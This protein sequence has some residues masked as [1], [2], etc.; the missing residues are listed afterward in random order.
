MWFTP[1]F[2]AFDRMPFGPK[3]MFR[4]FDMMYCISTM[5][6]RPRGAAVPLGDTLLVPVTEGEGHTAVTPE[7]HVETRPAER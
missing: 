2:I 5:E 6:R 1:L 3:M 4:A 7:V